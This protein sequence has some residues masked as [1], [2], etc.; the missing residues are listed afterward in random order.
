[1]REP[2][3]KKFEVNAVAQKDPTWCRIKKVSQS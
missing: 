2:A 1:M 3:K